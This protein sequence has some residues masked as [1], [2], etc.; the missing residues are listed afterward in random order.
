MDPL[1]HFS[2][3]AVPDQPGS[4]DRPGGRGGIPRRRGPAAPRS[5]PDLSRMSIEARRILGDG[6]WEW[7]VLRPDCGRPEVGR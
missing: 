2:P 1:M 6:L 5:R 7:L 4:V 3:G